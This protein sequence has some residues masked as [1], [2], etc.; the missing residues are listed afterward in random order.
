MFTWY[1]ESMTVYQLYDLQ[2]CS[3]EATCDT[4]AVI[5]AT[6]ANGGI[7]PITEEKVLKPESIRDVLSLM[8]SCGMY[9]YSGQFAF[10]VGHY[11]TASLTPFQV[12]QMSLVLPPLHPVSSSSITFFYITFTFPV[13]F[14]D[15]SPWPLHPSSVLPL[16]HHLQLLFLML[17]L[18][19]QSYFSHS[20]S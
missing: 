3:M 14:A 15:V 12:S 17:K 11:T 16:H 8:H 5:S 2:C 13:N 7:C 6:L 18:V 4:M 19:Q 9:D 10:K 20:L 1:L